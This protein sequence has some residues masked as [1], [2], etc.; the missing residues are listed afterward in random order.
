MSNTVTA[1]AGSEDS[2][3]VLVKKQKKFPW[4]ILLLLLPLILLIP[5]P[6]ELRIQFNKQDNGSLIP[7]ADNPAKV[8]YPEI[9]TF[10]RHSDKAVSQNTDSI[11]IFAITD[12]KEPL[13]HYLFAGSDSLHAICE[14]GCAGT[15]ARFS[16]QE[17]AKEDINRVTLG[18]KTTS[19]TMTVVD[20]ETNEPISN[21]TVTIILEDGTEK[22][23]TTNGNGQ[24][25]ADGMPACGKATIRAS[26][27]YYRNDEISGNVDDIKNKPDQERRLRL[28]PLK[29]NITVLVKDLKSRKPLPGATVTLNLDGSQLTLKSNSN[30]AGIAT[31]QDV[32]LMS[33]MDL[34]AHKSGYHD[35]TKTGYTVRE[36]IEL[37]EEDRTMYLRPIDKPKPPEPPQRQDPPSPPQRQDP[38]SPPQAD[39]KGQRGQLSIT[40]IWHCKADL[41]IYVTDPCGNQ[42]G[43]NNKQLTCNGSTGTIDIDANQNA[44]NEPETATTNPQENVF[45]NKANPG[46]YRIQINCCPLNRKMNLSSPGIPFT[47]VIVDRGKRTEQQGLIRGAY[48]NGLIDRDK[49]INN[50]WTY[51]VIE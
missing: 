11:G 28:E 49:V 35:T 17:F 50:F 18:S 2:E 38:P 36:F 23:V 46:K 47:V 40:L 45:W 34:L 31:F 44:T 9:S 1:T 6:R 32:R 20:R 42:L 25:A 7:V 24:F 41:D 26:K 48:T 22:T 8:I 29:G 27:E 16:Y 51:E 43:P 14:N 30:S 21:A 39:L 3:I 33:R 19:L 13:W 37:S 5:I 15:A 4:W 10:G 12:I